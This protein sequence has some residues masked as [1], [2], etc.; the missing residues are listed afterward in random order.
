MPLGNVLGEFTGKV[1]SVRHSDLGGGQVRLELDL[2]G[3]T[4]GQAR[5]QFF[6]TMVVEI[7]PGHPAPYSLTGV[8]LAASGAVMR[9]SV[10]GVGMR[11]GEGHKMRYR[12]ASCST[13]DDPTLAA[14]NNV[15]TAIEFETDPATMTVKGAV[16]EWQ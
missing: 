9:V 10:R 2:T 7:T 4:T 13:S 6:S 16:C 8:I 14:L 5:G 3:E 1:M 11:T 12:G 15:I